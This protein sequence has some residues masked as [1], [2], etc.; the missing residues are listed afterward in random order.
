[1]QSPQ[2]LIEF[3]VEIRTSVMRMSTSRL[4]L[5]SQPGA[6]LMPATPAGARSKASGS[7]SRRIA[8][9]ATARSTSNAI[10][11]LTI[12]P[13]SAIS[14]GALRNRSRRV[15]RPQSGRVW[16]RQP[17]TWAVTTARTVTSASS[18]PA[19][20]R[21]APSA[22]GCVVTRSIPSVPRRCGRRAK[23]W[24]GNGPDRYPFFR[25]VTSSLFAAGC[26]SPARPSAS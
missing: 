20:S 8:P 23:R 16:S 17:T 9:L 22:K 11:A 19:M 7:M 18:C 2:R 25:D 21:S 26:F 1:M 10:A 3:T 14:G 24:W 5:S 12:A 6:E 13:D 15:G 4:A